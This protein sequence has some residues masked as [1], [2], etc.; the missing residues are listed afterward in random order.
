MLKFA[1]ALSL[2]LGAVPMQN[3]SLAVPATEAGLAQVA[4]FM[5]AKPYV[6]TLRIEAH[7]DGSGDARNELARSC[8]RAHA[9]ARELVAL[10]VPCERLLPVG[11]GADKPVAARGSKENRRI[12]FT[13]AALRGKAIGG[14]PLDGG[15]Q[16]A[17]AACEDQ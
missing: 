7:T 13:P 1:L 6:T 17:T 2:A 3:G 14:M 8:Q 16:Q 5:K 15:G 10:G 9:I 12:V 11:F 4:E